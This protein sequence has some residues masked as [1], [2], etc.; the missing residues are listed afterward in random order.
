MRYYTMPVYGDSDRSLF[1]GRILIVDDEPANVMLL[2]RVLEQ[3]GYTAVRSTTD[4]RQVLKLFDE[5]Q[6][7]LVLLDLLMPHVDGFQVMRQLM[8]RVKSH[9]YL[10]ILVLTADITARAKQEALSAGAKDFLTKPFDL[11]EVLLRIHNLLETRFLHLQLLRQNDE[12]ED[13]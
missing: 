10:P 9:S 8:A 11:T 13:R 12:L 4:S 3:G 1:E 2:E 6:P 5:F 7:D